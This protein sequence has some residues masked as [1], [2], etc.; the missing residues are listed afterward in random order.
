MNYFC[1]NYFYP[2]DSAE[3][4]ATRPVHREFL[5]SLKEQG[6]LVGSGPFLDEDGGALIIIRLEESATLDDAIQLMSKDPFQQQ[7]VLDAV[8]IRPWNPVMNVFA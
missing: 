7:G 1:V 8:K 5:G 4:A 3:I 2:A 6:I